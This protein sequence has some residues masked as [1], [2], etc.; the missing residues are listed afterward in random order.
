V[1]KRRLEKACHLMVTT[2]DSLGEIAF[3]LGFADQAH[4]ARHFRR[5]FGQS[6]STWRRDQGDNVKRGWGTRAHAD[7]TLG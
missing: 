6:P 4:L 7:R 5:A 3:S 2:S 1:I